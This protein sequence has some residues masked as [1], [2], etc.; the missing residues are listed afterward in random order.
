VRA[1]D[2][3]PAGI[4]PL[5]GL[6]ALLLDARASGHAHALALSCD[7]PYLEAP[8]IVRLATE[9]PAASFLAPREGELWQ[10]LVA[11][12]AVAALPAVDAA[13]AAGDRALQRVVARLG[14]RAVELLVNESERA[15]LRDWDEPGDAPS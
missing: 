11:R 2:D 10:T 13:I 7:L 1:L 14:E 5:G 3:A 9:A 6:R 8:L 4:G 12:Y 15:E